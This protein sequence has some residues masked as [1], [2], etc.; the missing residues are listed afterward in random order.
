MLWGGLLCGQTVIAPVVEGGA[1]VPTPPCVTGQVYFNT[2]AAA[3]QNLYVCASNTWTQINGVVANLAST[4]TSNTFAAGTTQSFLGTF[5]A[6]GAAATLPA[7]TGATLPATCSTGQLFLETGV[8]PSR[9]LYICSA[10]N[11][12][13]QVG[14]AQGTTAQMPATCAAGRM[15]FATDATA[16]SNLY[17]CTSS[18]TWTQMAGC[19]SCVTGP[20][21]STSTYVPQWSGTT[22]TVLGAG[23]PAAT[24]ATASSIAERDSSGNLT[25]NTF[26]TG[27]ASIGGYTTNFA[28]RLYAGTIDYVTC[29][30]SAATLNPSYSSH[31]VNLNNQASCTITIAAGTPYQ[32]G[33]ILLCNGSSTATTTLTWSGLKGGMAAGGTTSQCAGQT[34]YYD[35]GNSKWYATSSGAS[36]N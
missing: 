9:M 11:T 29:T 34:I 14:F 15:Y 23:L 13:S 5:D 8:D 30:A 4:N 20:G 17:F 10:A 28:W 6:S 16:G 32:W 27:G 36:W 25:A 24:A 22:G 31:R 7:Q 33:T 19:L 21:S 1:S 18:N 12:W 35:D 2:S 26:N 3:G